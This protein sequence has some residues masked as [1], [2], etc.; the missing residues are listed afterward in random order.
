MLTILS[1]VL[2][3]ALIVLQYYM[4]S[5]LIF[6]SVLLRESKKSWLIAFVLVAPIASVLYFIREYWRYR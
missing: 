5:H 4:M 3:I 6:D 2:S 1:F